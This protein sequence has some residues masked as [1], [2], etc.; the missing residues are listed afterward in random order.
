ARRREQAEALKQALAPDTPGTVL[1]FGD[2]A[3]G[4]V[5]TRTGLLVNATPVGMH[6]GS[7]LD[8]GQVAR[9]PRQAYVADL[10]Y[11]PAETPLMAMART[12]GLAVGNGLEMLLCQ[13]AA[14][15]ERWTGVRPP[16][17]VLR[18]AVAHPEGRPPCSAS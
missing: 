8:A 16:L 12:R 7:P 6:G 15:F 2:E 10:I 13:A 3:L 4:G 14:A 1:G 18:Q 11:N 17:E 5:L 9:L